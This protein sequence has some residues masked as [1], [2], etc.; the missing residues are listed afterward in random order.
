M[1]SWNDILVLL[2]ELYLVAAV[3]LLLLLDAFMRPE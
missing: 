1:L 3:C 2:P